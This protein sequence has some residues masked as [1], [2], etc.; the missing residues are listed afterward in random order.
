MGHATS[1]YGKENYV[2]FRKLWIL[3]ADKKVK[4][5]DLVRAGLNRATIYA[6]RDNENVT[7]A[8]IAKLC[9]TLQCRIEDICEFVECPKDGIDIPEAFL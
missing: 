6:L 1:D 5:M 8:T 4:K 9:H 2:D 7:C 3:M